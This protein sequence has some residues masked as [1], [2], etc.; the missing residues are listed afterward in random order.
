M[1]GADGVPRLFARGNAALK[2]TVRAGARSMYGERGIERF[3]C[4][5]LKQCAKMKLAENGQI[6]TFCAARESAGAAAARRSS[7]DC[8]MRI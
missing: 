8:K 7:C 2:K 6:R 1:F 3:A 5:F 4:M